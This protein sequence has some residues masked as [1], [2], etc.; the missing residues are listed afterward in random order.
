MLFSCSHCQID[1]PIKLYGRDVDRT[2]SIKFLG[3]FLDET[4]N[5]TKHTNY[6]SGKIAK[7][8][9]IMNKV[10]FLPSHV[11]CTIYH[12]MVAPYILYGIK[13]WYG[14]PN[15]NR[16]RIQVLQNKC[17]RIIKN[18]DRRTNSDSERKLLGILNVGNI[19]VHQVGQFMS[20]IIH[21][22]NPN[23]EF[24]FILNQSTPLHNYPT[25]NVINLRPPR[26]DRTKC[27]HSMEYSGIIVWNQIPEVIRNVETTSIFKNQLKK[28]LL[29]L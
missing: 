17:I 29:T 26:V 3:V 19:Y 14:C 16:N 8:I 20:N 13:A 24:S 10:R 2:P 7:T 18:L 25:R 15:Y 6:I 5:F 22:D 9:G 4:L 11:L 12:T 27:R 28:Y 1:V 23:S 21:C